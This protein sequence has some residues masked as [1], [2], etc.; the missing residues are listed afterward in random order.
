MAATA[1]PQPSAAEAVSTPS[2]SFADVLRQHPRPA[3]LVHQ[4]RA[5]ASGHPSIVR[6]LA[7]YKGR[8]TVFFSEEDVQTLSTPFW[9]A[10]IGK[11]SRD[12]PNME[13]LWKE[14]RTIGFKGD[15]TIGQLDP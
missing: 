6:E 8:P 7:S 3:P 15:Y 11:F 2:K 13:S 9:F 4:H 1:T 14:F 5:L 10:L 12:Q